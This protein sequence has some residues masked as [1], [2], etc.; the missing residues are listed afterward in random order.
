MAVISVIAFALLV[1]TGLSETFRS[2]AQKRELAPEAATITGRVFQD[3]NSNGAYDTAV[4]FNSI[5]TGVAGVTVSAF[6]SNGVARGT[7]IGIASPNAAYS[8]CS[9]AK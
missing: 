6:D 9:C 2:T 7:T 3:F 5:D 8:G 1:F 4:G